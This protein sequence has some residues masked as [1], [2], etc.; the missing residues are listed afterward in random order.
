[1]RKLGN[2]L[3][4]LAGHKRDLREWRYRTQ[5]QI[6][7]LKELARTEKPAETKFQ[8]LYFRLAGKVS[9]FYTASIY[10]LSVPGK[11]INESIPKTPTKWTLAD[12]A[13]GPA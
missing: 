1:M 12:Y 10:S 9:L 8:L 4:E 13:V 7:K 11:N 2:G 6:N 5:G 3:T